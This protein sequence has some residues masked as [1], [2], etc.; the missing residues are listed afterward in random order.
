MPSRSYLPRI[1]TAWNHTTVRWFKTLM[2]IGI[3]ANIIVAAI[4]VIWTESVLDFLHLDQPLV[5]PRFDACFASFTLL[6]PS[7]RLVTVTRQSCR[8]FVVWR[9]RV[10]FDCTGR[11]I[12]FGLFDLMFGL[13]QAILF[14]I[15]GRSSPLFFRVKR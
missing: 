9:R 13:P 8:S 3:V 1:E 11:Y 6:L 2:W 4:S 10:F 5:W 14:W 12:V 7:I 15:T